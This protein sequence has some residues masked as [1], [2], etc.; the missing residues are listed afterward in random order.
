MTPKKQIRTEVDTPSS[1]PSN[2]RP[3]DPQRH[4]KKAEPQEHPVIERPSRPDVQE[5]PAKPKRDVPYTDPQRA[6][7]PQAH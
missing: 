4:E 7:E 2:P 3:S 6:D 5:F 1:P